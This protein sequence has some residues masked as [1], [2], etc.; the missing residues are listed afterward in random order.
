MPSPD[1][2]HPIGLLGSLRRHL[3]REVRD[4]LLVGGAG[5]V[6]DVA[7][8]NLLRSSPAASG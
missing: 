8:F 4:F 1:L 7:L 2:A 3:T 6:V 5:F